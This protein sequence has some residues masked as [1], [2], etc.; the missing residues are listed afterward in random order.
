[1]RSPLQRDLGVVDIPAM[2]RGIPVAAPIDA[3]VDSWVRARAMASLYLAGAVIGVLS[4]ILPH[5]AK[6]D[7]PALW[8]NVALAFLAGALLMTIGSRL[9]SWAFHV[10]LALGSVLV[11]RAVLASGDPV[12]FYSVWY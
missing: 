8:S 4:M 10:G 9:P 1:M 3:G 11:T 6:A 7:D 2:T 12:S 5:A